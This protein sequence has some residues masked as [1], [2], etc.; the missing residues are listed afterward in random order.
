MPHG[1]SGGQKMLRER[2]GR[3]LVRPPYLSH[4]NLE[5]CVAGPLDKPALG[6]GGISAQGAADI[7]ESG[8]DAFGHVAH[9]SYDSECKQGAN[10][11]VFNQI[12]AI[13]AVQQI[14]ELQ[15]E[16]QK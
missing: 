3:G 10:H 13:L 7:A 5:I 12:L 6:L 14:L 1:L 16:I 8:V 4:E 15:V 2:P 11:G 9:A